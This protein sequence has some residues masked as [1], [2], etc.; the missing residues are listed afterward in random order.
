MGTGASNA[1]SSPVTLCGFILPYEYAILSWFMPAEFFSKIPPQA[2]L[3]VLDLGFLGD[4]IHLIPSLAV[5]RRA[6]PQARL[7]VMVA[8][9]VQSILAVCPWLD[10]VSGYP[11]Y[12]KGP[13]WYE[14]F[15]R[16]RALRAKKFDVV[17][18]LNGSRRSS[19][20]TRFSGAPLRFGRIQRR[21]SPAWL[22]C[23]T[24]QVS[25]PFDTEPLY[26]Q[27]LDALAAAG[28]PG[29][30]EGELFP[31]EI[32]TV[33][34]EKVAGLLNGN[35][36]YLHVSPFA[37]SDEKELAP[38]VL[39]GVLNAVAAARPDLAF[40]LSTAPNQRERTKLAALISRLKFSP[41]K[42]FP[43]D[44]NL[45]ELAEVMRRAQLHLGG[46]SGALHVALMAGAPTF[47]WWRD[48]AG[49][50]EWMP[51]GS[52]HAAVVGRCGAQAIEG[53]EAKNTT[54]IILSHLDKIAANLGRGL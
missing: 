35:R 51:Q 22:H 28:F 33:V 32:P 7:E 45:V 24:H 46:D 18:N 5:I 48:Y 19:F 21:S 47:S 53:I 2:R 42:T 54:A 38:E 52:Q 49:R 17:I 37:T 13:K 8:E 23:Y 36:P 3:L 1:K 6:L 12:P 30:G 27:R 31:I 44:L 43:G 4:T 14:D 16:I 41:A 40:I 20:L 10:A 15:G 39:A 25:I 50:V 11:R 29:V 9:H 34:K 26:R